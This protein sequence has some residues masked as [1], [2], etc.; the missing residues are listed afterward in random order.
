MISFKDFTDFCVS[1]T[2]FIADELRECKDNPTFTL[3]S[4]ETVVTKVDLSVEDCLRQSISEN[5]PEHCIKG[6]ERQT[7]NETSNLQWII[8]PIDGTYSFTKGVPLFGT[9]IGLLE[10]NKPKY[11]FLRMPLIQNSWMSGDGFK[12]LK[13][14]KMLSVNAHSSWKNSLI[15]TTDQ[16]T[17]EN[18]T[19]FTHWE[20]A[21]DCGATART[22]GDCFGYYLLCLGKAEMM[23][24]VGLKS[25]DILP[26]IPILLGSG[27]DVIPIEC[28]DYQNIIASKPGVWSQIK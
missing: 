10:K 5:F 19:L 14:G 8:D 26:L 20:K 4:D 15:L 18:S 21:L 28:N 16:Q 11:G 23:V 9:L 25:F 2:E 22:W 13:D 17:L 7:V 12:A 24:D 3:K 1:Q 27:V 6:E